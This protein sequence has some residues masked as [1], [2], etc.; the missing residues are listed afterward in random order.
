MLWDK[1]SNGMT[2]EY[3]YFLVKVS[4]IHI[5]YVDFNRIVGYQEN[6]IIQGFNVLSQEKTEKFLNA[7]HLHHL[8]M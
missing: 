6:Y 3:I 1:D 5:P 2:W 8:I 4:D 7:Y